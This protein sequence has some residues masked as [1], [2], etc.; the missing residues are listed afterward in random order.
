MPLPPISDITISNR[1]FTFCKGARGVAANDDPRLVE[2]S[3]A[4]EL[5]HVVTTSYGSICDE[6]QGVV[7]IHRL[8]AFN[9]LILRRREALT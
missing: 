7:K 4:G 5:L 1:S 9:P 2:G 6:D 3:L 8:M